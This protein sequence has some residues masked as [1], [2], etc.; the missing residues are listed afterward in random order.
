MSDYVGLLGSCEVARVEHWR[1]ESLDIILDEASSTVGRWME[2]LTGCDDS[3]NDAEA[4]NRA[5][6]QLGVLRLAQMRSLAVRHYTSA[7]CLIATVAVIVPRRC[8]A[9]S[10]L[11]AFCSS[12]ELYE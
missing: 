5:W 8:R 12:D 11:W 10:A 3:C 7:K 1:H 4:R 9:S 2:A 6:G